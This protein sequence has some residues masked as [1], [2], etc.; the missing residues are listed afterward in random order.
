[1]QVH[2][3]P[4]IKG[5]LTLSN[6]TATH[7]PLSNT[8]GMPMTATFAYLRVS[9]NDDVMTT[10]NQRLELEQAGH[11]IDYWYEDTISGSTQAMARPGFAA[12]VDKMRNGESLI[13][14]KLDRLGRDAIDVMATVRLFAERDIRVI[15]HS[16]G[17]VDLASPTGKLLV[18]ML[19]AVAEMERD[20]LIER[21]RAGIARARSEGKAIGR[22]SKT[23]PEQRA[24]ML[25]CLAVGA[26]VSAVARAFGISRA[27]V[28]AVRGAAAE[29]TDGPVARQTGASLLRGALTVKDRLAA[30]GGAL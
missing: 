26:S 4:V 27:A 29:R 7:A 10:A 13:V 6:M 25:A 16:L 11:R 14:S 22:P 2:V 23:T 24:D 28:I 12:M 15:V 19:A 17:G 20:L 3:E 5:G 8:L 18:T 9:K 21:T 30:V 1:V